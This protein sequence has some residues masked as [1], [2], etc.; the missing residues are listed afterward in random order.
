MFYRL[1]WKYRVCHSRKDFQHTLYT[2]HCARSRSITI[3]IKI[4]IGLLFRGG[5]GSEFVPYNNARNPCPVCEPGRGGWKD[6]LPEKP[7]IG[8]H[9]RILFADD[10]ITTPAESRDSRKTITVT[11]LPNS[12]LKSE[13]EGV[14]SRRTVID[15]RPPGA[16]YG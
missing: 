13:G 2:T 6:D 5:W 3:R 12:R 7:K 9:A 15:D 14:G 8:T 11:Q 16:V 1:L 4:R 10:L